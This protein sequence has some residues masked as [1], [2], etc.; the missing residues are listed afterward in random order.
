[1]NNRQ[2]W[3]KVDRDTREPHDERGIGPDSQKTREAVEAG[4]NVTGNVR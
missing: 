3:M 4:K 2:A 1:M